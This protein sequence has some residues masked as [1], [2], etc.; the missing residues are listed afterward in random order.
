MAA[1]GVRYAVALLD[2]CEERGGLQEAL[3]QAAMLLDALKSEECHTLLGHPL[4]SRSDKRSFLEG[5]FAQSVHSDLMGFMLLA[6]EKKREAHILPALEAFLDMGNHRCGKTT[7]SVVSATPLSQRQIDRIKDM[8]SKKL[9]KQVDIQ[10]T[11]NP[12]LIGGLYIHVD[13][14]LIDRTIRKQL[15][16]MRES[17]KE[18]SGDY[19]T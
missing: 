1:L 4:I 12:A 15:N 14:Y 7:A 17:I 11:T 6:V 19:G 16:D 8:L 13:G 3:G 5:A 9:D 10:A 2:L 18:G